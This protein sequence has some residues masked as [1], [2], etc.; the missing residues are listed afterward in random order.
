MMSPA[1][2]SVNPHMLL[3]LAST[4]LTDANLGLF[5]VSELLLL[6]PLPLLPLSDELSPPELS[7]SA[8]KSLSSRVH[9]ADVNIALS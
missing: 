1:A 6:P 7:S 9:L 2:I 8:V 5:F 3:M 4:A